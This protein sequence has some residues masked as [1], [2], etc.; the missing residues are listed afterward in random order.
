MQ[1]EPFSVMRE[2]RE[3]C[4]R[5]GAASQLAGR[6]T[7]RCRPKCIWELESGVAKE[8][9]CTVT[10]LTG[11]DLQQMVSGCFSLAQQRVILLTPLL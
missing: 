11:G 5:Q 8:L 4:S 10:A 3:D 9:T 1:A 7:E 2:I 6:N